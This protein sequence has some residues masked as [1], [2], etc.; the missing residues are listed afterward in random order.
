MDWTRRAKRLALFTVS[1]NLVEGLVSV[2]FGV[3]G[4]SVALAGFGV[5]SFI[6]VG[7]AL[8]VL[9]RLRGA[10]GEDRERRAA[11]SIGVLFLFLATLTALG[12]TF[13]LWRR[14]PPDTTMPGIVISLASLSFMF[15]LWRAKLETGKALASSAI[16]GD[17]ACSLACI[18]LSIV[19]LAGSLV[20][21][22]LPVLWWADSIAALILSALIARE[23]WE[24]FSGDSDCCCPK[25]SAS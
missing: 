1:Y 7:S 5:D 11:R 12:S 17:A 10:V 20:Y 21:A 13:Q 4:E 24:M 25:T 23:G 18:K 3:R 19:L 8:V 9:W 22:M 6:E 14:A 16:L 2:A 15:W